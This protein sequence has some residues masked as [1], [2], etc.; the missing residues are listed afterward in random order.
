MD[1]EKTI[2]HAL[3]ATWQAVAKTYNE[4]A[5]K[6]DFTMAMAMALLYIDFENGTPST[7]LGPSMGMEATSL[8]R[9]LKNMEERGLIYREQNPED[10][11]SVLLKLT[12][13]GKEKREISKLSVLKF[14]QTIKENISQE[15]IN[16]FFE[17]TDLINNL[18]NQNGI[19]KN[20]Q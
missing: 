15:K 8:S 11:R 1:K 17:V 5:G 6:Y 7:A 9:I 18:I 12:K 19:F 4:Q 20:D 2:D 14:N 3:R 16:H 13:L 10:G